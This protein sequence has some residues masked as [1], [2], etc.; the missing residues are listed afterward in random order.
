MSNQIDW[1]VFDEAFKKHYSPNQ[2]RPSKPIR[3]MVSLLILKQLRNLSDESVVEQWSENAY[4]QYFSGEKVF[5]S[6]QP[7]VPTELV[8]FRKRIG[9]SGVE[10]ILKESIRVNGND[11][12]DDH[13]SGDTTVQEKN[14]TYP[15]DDKLYK[16]II[17]KCRSIAEKEGIELRQSYIFTVKKLSTIQRFR[18]N[19][20]GDMKARKASKKIKTIA[21]RLIC[22]VGRKLRA[23]ALNNYRSDLNLF[24]KVLAQ[25]RGD[26]NKFI[27][28]TNLK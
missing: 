17:S 4:Y 23:T 27:V 28:F 13:L 18:R 3:L 22:D 12:D 14:I 9:E 21:E 8:E 20:G 5:S 15:T 24:T 16:K 2:G 10:L 6:K 25:K 1:T 26:S 11:A 19:K 7:C